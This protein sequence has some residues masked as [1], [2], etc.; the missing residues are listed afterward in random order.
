MQE[1]GEAGQ[2]RHLQTSGLCAPGRGQQREPGGDGGQGRWSDPRSPDA[3]SDGPRGL[4]GGRSEEHT[5]E[6][7]SRTGISYAVFCL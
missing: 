1:E 3:G 4:G 2:E 5:S 6:L 7:Q